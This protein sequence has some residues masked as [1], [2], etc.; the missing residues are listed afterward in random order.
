M[1]LAIHRYDNI[2]VC[3]ALDVV[4]DRIIFHIGPLVGSPLYFGL[5]L[6]SN[7]ENVGVATTLL[8]NLDIWVIPSDVWLQSALCSKSTFWVVPFPCYGSNCC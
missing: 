6:I 1:F 8:P 5:I 3:I 7:R 4:R 2:R